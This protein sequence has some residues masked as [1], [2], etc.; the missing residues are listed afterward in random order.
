MEHTHKITDM[1]LEIWDNADTENTPPL[2][3]Q[4]HWPNG[5]PWG[6]EQEITAW[7]EAKITELADPKSEFVAGS[8]SDEPLAIRK[9]AV[10]IEIPAPKTPE[11][12]ALERQAVI[13]KLAALGLTIEEVK[14]AT[15]A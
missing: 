2:I 5:D 1:V 13:E 10:E 3:R 8:S 12:E 7:A 4:P 14:L 9:P 11:Q 6:S 15:G